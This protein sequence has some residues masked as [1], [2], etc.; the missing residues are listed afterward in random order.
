M[1]T[2][3]HISISTG[4]TC[5]AAVDLQAMPGHGDAYDFVFES[6]D[7]HFALAFDAPT[8]AHFIDLAQNLLAQQAAPP[9][10]P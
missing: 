8:L 9:A 1:Q 2:N 6:D 4:V 5:T 7:Q 3:S 10:A